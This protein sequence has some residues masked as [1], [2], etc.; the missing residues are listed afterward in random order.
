M[1]ITK[2]IAIS[3]SV[4]AGG[5]NKPDDVR[6]VQEQLN[7]QMSPPRQPLVVD[8]ICGPLTRAMIRDSQENVCGHTPPD[9][10]VDVG[11]STIQALNDPNSEAIWAGVPNVG[12]LPPDNPSGPVDPVA[13]C[14]P[15]VATFEG[16]PQRAT[17]FAFDDR[18]NLVNTADTGEYWIPQASPAQRHQ[19]PVPQTSSGFA[20]QGCFQSACDHHRTRSRAHRQYGHVHR[21]DQGSEHHGARPVES[22]GVLA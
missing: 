14:C 16:L 9:G 21:Q 1:A 17:Y 7:A 10:R 6:A 2:S 20:E 4:G 12:P 18:T 3:A 22:D 13:K 15:D 5:A 11:F 19:G 8:G